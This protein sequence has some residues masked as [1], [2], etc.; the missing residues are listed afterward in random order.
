[1]SPRDIF[2]LL[3][4]FFVSLSVGH[5]TPAY[6]DKTSV[7]EYFFVDLR[8]SSSGQCAAVTLPIYLCVYDRDHK[9]AGEGYHPQQ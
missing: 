1:L 4:I 9:K 6:L 5:P 2:C 3:G 7:K 8:I